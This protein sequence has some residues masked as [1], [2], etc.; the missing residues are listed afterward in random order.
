MTD[1]QVREGVWRNRSGQRVV[2]TQCDPLNGQQWTDGMYHVHDDGKFSAGRQSNPD[3]VEYLGPFWTADQSAEI[4]RLKAE[5]QQAETWRVAATDAEEQSN[6]Q[7]AEIDR[8]Q[9]DCYREFT[10]AQKLRSEVEQLQQ[11]LDEARQE[12][13]EWRANARAM[14]HHAEGMK[15][16]FL[17]TIKALAGGRGR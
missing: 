12:S 14:D 5:L 13:Q 10:A 7:Q 6:I 2:V 8:L 4:D 16:A 17:L 3:L 15:A 11:Q 1:I 9:S